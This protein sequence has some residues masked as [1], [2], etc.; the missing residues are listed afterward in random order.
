MENPRASN[1]DT[2]KFAAL[3]NVPG[4]F[5]VW[6]ASTQASFLHGRYVWAEW[7]VNELENLQERLKNDE[8]L[9]R[10]GVHGI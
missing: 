3:A 4:Q 9:L 5:A 8:N 6:A 10:I 1:A 2:S 7:D